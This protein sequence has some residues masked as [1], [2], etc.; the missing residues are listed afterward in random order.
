MEEHTKP[1]FFKSFSVLFFL[2]LL[3]SEAIAMNNLLIDD[4]PMKN[5]LNDPNSAIHLPPFNKRLEALKLPYL[6]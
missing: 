6:L 4:S 5:L 2:R 3:P 1:Y